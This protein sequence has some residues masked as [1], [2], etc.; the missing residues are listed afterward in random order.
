M[1]CLA[2]CLACM[3]WCLW[4]GWFVSGVFYVLKCFLCGECVFVFAWFLYVLCLDVCCAF[5]VGAWCMVC[6]CGGVPVACFVIV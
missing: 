6:V 4:H 1:V 3:W 5:V 2:V